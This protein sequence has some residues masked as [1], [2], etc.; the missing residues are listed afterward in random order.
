VR[1]ALV[2]GALLIAHPTRA[3]SADQLVGLFMQACLPFA[4]DT[5][6]LRKWAARIGLQA[7]PPGGQAAFLQGQPGLA[8]DATNTEG[9]FVVISGDGG[10]CAAVAD[11]G[12]PA[13]TTTGLEQALGA[14]G[15]GF[16]VT[17]DRDDSQERAL[18]YREYRARKG[19]RAWRIV[20]ST[21]APD[22]G[23]HPMLSATPE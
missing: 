1:G 7:L 19:G 20:L 22:S 14:A 5:A 9:K 3:D 10:A 8:F 6:G 17:A 16:V 21:G 18:H 2:L 12:A 13:R 23:A 11:R 4:G 15:F